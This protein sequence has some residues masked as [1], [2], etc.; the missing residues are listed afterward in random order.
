MGT[1]GIALVGPMHSG[2]TTF[3]NLLI[4]DNSMHTRLAFA[5]PVKEVS[6]AML[7]EFVRETDGLMGEMNSYQ[8]D[9][10][11]ADMNAMKGHPSIRKLLQLVG[12]ELGREWRGPQ[13]LWIDIFEKKYKEYA[14]QMAV[15]RTEGFVVNDDCR[16]LNEAAR[17]K[18]LGFLII[19]LARDEHGRKESILASL[20]QQH[21]TATLGDLFEMLDKMLEH[22]SEVEQRDIQAD[23][24]FYAHNTQDLALFA[25]FAQRYTDQE[26]KERY[27]N[28]D[29]RI[30]TVW[31]YMTKKEIESLLLTLSP[32]QRKRVDEHR[33]QQESASNES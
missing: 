11:I 7:A 18:E 23:V 28:G 14:S 1:R 17:L 2:K 6:G 29:D 8:R 12:T 10:S 26:I 22:P 5:D 19:R 9:Y 20:A 30:G 27:N 24:T 32:S 13:S 31:D 4:D 16:F 33:K 3:S 15:M 25:A 21:P